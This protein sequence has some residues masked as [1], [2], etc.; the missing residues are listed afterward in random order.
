MTTRNAGVSSRLAAIRLHLRGVKRRLLWVFVSF[1]L[2]AS[3][4][5]YFN[6]TVILWLLLPAHGQLSATG[7]PVFTAPTDMISLVVKLATV[8]GFVLAVPVL[9]YQVF[10]FIRP[11]LSKKLTRFLAIFLPAM[12]VCFLCG[13]AFAYF[14]LLPTGLGFLLQFGTDVADPL[15]RIT[16]YMDLTL[17]MLFWLGIVF[18]LPL[19]MFLLAKMR[20]VS[21]KRFARFSRYVPA[22]AFI[23]GAII[24]PTFDP[25]TVFFVA[26]PLIVLFGVGTFLAWLARPRTKKARAG[27]NP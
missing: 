3:L 2:G 6:K 25:V 20:I 12:L 11:L 18:E 17:A 4:T 21:Y 10:Q 5:W 15:V 13:A 8:G 27:R 23:L 7:R 24:T 26:G 19:A 14:V 9:V 16:E 1:G 22:A